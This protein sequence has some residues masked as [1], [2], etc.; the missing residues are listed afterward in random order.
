MSLHPW[1]K[2]SESVVY[3]NRWWT[4]K[5]DEVL[6]PSGEPGEYH[7]VHSLGSAMVVPIMSDGKILT[8]KQYRHLAEMESIE[9]PC[10]SVKAGSSHD[11]TAWKELIE[12]TGFASDHL[13]LVGKFNPYNGV[14][15]E[16]CHVYVARNL[17]HV[18]A[19]PDET[20]E[21]ELLPLTIDEIDRMIANGTIWDGMS[22]AG[23]HLVRSGIQL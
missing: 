9:L 15:N 7:Y 6:L 13:A 19:L 21:F 17:R 12:E 2:L 4:Y 18:G 5:R 22:I 14:T 20:E 23:W 1:K 11:E 8:V 3:S 16:M 10:G